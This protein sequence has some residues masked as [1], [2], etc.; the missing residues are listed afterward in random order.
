MP[1]TPRCPFFPVSFPRV[2]LPFRFTYRA[3]RTVHVLQFDRAIFF[4]KWPQFGAK[5]QRSSGIRPRPSR[6][7]RSDASD[8]QHREGKGREGKGW[9]L[10]R[11][12]GRRRR[13]GRKGFAEVI[14]TDKRMGRNLNY[15]SAVHRTN[16]PTRRRDG[17]LSK[18][19]RETG[20]REGPFEMQAQAEMLL[21]K[22][23]SRGP[24]L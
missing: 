18:Q 8:H 24:L 7:L 22:L 20:E 4:K 3:T 2:V 1:R 15:T 13:E 12:R 21:P 16:M 19:R 17:E 9:D 14:L 6:L 10:G 23:R 11:G 5:A